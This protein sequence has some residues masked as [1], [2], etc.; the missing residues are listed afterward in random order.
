[1]AIAL[2]DLGRARSF[3]LCEHLVQ[4]RVGYLSIGRVNA[5]TVPLDP[6]DDMDVE[7]VDDLPGLAALVDEYVEPFECEPAFQALG[8]VPDS[9]EGLLYLPVGAVDDELEVLLGHDE[10]MAWRSGIDVEEGDYG[11]VLV[12]LSR[13]YCASHDLA[14]HAILRREF[15]LPFLL[16]FLFCHVQLPR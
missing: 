1:M 16:A 10:A 14:K 15:L 6:G 9:N 3:Q 12:E 7:V 13:G 5:Q 8:G 2:F 11:F 4:F